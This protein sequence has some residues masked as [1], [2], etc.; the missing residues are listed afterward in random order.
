LTVKPHFKASVVVSVLFSVLCSVIYPVSILTRVALFS[1]PSSTVKLNALL[2]VHFAPG[3]RG[4]AIE[5][6]A[7]A[8][9]DQ[10]VGRC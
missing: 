2:L 4:R 5:L 9:A 3:V 8:A 1:R 10:F 6:G 7:Y